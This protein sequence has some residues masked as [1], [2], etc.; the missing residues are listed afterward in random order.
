M[1]LTPIPPYSKNTITNAIALLYEGQAAQL[2]SLCC[3]PA[4]LIWA[5]SYAS[6][7]K[8][9]SLELPQA[10]T[11]NAGALIGLKQ[12]SNQRPYHAPQ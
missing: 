8:L 11:L 2:L 9:L 5:S 4:M 3:Q 6:L 1:N 12:K 10:P 7:G